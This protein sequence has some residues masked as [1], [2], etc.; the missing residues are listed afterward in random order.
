MA[1]IRKRKNGS[2]QAAV[3]VGLSTEIDPKTGKP[4][5]L[6]EY[7][8]MEGFKEI[9]EAA[10]NLEKD[11]ADK[12]YSNMQNCLFSTYSQ[13]WLEINENLVSPTTFVKNYKMYVE[14]HFI[15]FFGRF[16]L[17]DIT[18]FQ[19]KE[20]INLKLKTLSPT[21]VRKH[22]YTLNKM[23]YDALKL[24]NPCRDITPPE[25]AEYIPQVP[26]DEEFKLLH[27]AVKGTFDEPIILL[28]GW[29]GLR[30]GEI[31]CLNTD[32]IDE[33]NGTVR[34]DE[35]KAIS[36]NKNI[37][38]MKLSNEQTVEKQAINKKEPK[39]IYQSKGPK[40]KRG[41][42]TLVVK[43]YLMQLL[44]KLK[45]ERLAEYEVDKVIE[46]TKKPI[47][48]F[49]MRPDSYS[50]RFS[51]I[52]KFHNEMFDIRKKFGQAGLDNSLKPHTKKSIRKNLNLQNKK[53]KDFRFHDLR[54]Y[55]VTV[56]YENEIPDQYAAER[57]GDDIKTMKSVYQHLRLD[58][59]KEID[60]KI[61]NI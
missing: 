58:K 16:K 22:F 38:E 39:L 50:S 36:E 42:R 10:R 20:Y 12:T 26:T 53:L 60:T 25:E 21:T 28:A 56:M 32:D 11:I 45:H 30:E 24:K 2:Y 46:L 8:T 40:S 5:K 41:F 47:P 29:C 37:K 6:Y 15:P 33:I 51:D 61:K 55:H 35:S 23:L 48:L 18:E 14:K 17:K 7:I 1:Y 9:K 43:D 19:V 59:R 44:K 13:K 49:N 27:A 52:I 54:H 3:Y 57:L 34:I 4:K 31:F